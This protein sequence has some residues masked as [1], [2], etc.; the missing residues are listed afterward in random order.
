MEK[1]LLD[2]PDLLNQMNEAKFNNCLDSKTFS[3]VYDKTNYLFYKQTMLGKI[4]N[5]R[6]E[7]YIANAPSN[8]RIFTYN[9]HGLEEVYNNLISNIDKLK[10][11]LIDNSKKEETYQKAV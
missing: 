5:E 1:K 6:M 7:D 8:D 10:P 2:I 3:Q 9:H 11:Y 4:S